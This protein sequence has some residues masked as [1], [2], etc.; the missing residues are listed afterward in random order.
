M[1]SLCVSNQIQDEEVRINF[2]ERV[3]N[4]EETRDEK[5]VCFCGKKE[6]QCD[7]INEIA[8]AF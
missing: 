3:G 5:S 4:I 1:N 8:L 7:M 6:S 2:S